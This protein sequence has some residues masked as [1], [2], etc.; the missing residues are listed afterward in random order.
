MKNKWLIGLTVLLL[1]FSVNAAEEDESLRPVPSVSGETGIFNVYEA[2]TLNFKQL[3]TQISYE[4]WDRDPGNLDISEEALSFGYGLTDKLEVSLSLRAKQIKADPDPSAPRAYY[5]GHWVDRKEYHTGTGDPHFGLKYNFLKE[6]KGVPGLAVQAYTD[7]PR[8]DEDTLLGAGKTDYGINVIVSKTLGP[9]ALSANV[10]YEELNK[11]DLA[12]P[13]DQPSKGLYGLGVRFPV[14]SRLQGILEAK[15]YWL[16]D[17]KKIFRQEE[18]TDLVLGGRWAFYNG[19]GIAAGFQYTPEMETDDGYGGIVK[20]SYT[21][22]VEKEKEKEKL[23]LASDKASAKDRPKARPET[24]PKA[25]NLPPDLKVTSD[26]TIVEEDKSVP[27]T[28]IASDPDGDPLTYEWETDKGEII[29][30]GKEVSWKPE[31]GQTGPAHIV[32]KVSDGKGGTT[33]DTIDMKVEEKKIPKREFATVFFEFDKYELDIRSKEKIREVCNYL[34]EY[35]EAGIKIE[36]HT[37]DIATEEYNLALGE[38]RANAIKDFIVNECGID[39]SRIST[40]SYGE[41]KPEYD[42]SQESTKQY[43]RRGEFKVI[44]K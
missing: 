19:W 5:L 15:G 1:V 41:S 21:S 33:T 12:N 13:T 44:V 30:S 40:I 6:K 42:N 9:V 39:A 3:S 35:P 38:H 36:G 23:K 18:H 28:A 27:V 16:V 34:K 2:R 22:K 26:R 10:G 8:T 20:I 17:D 37:C 11:T 29:G 25:V 4:N 31:P 43:N 14:K 32:S 24:T 7:L